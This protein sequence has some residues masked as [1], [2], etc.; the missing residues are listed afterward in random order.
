MFFSCE[1]FSQIDL[2]IIK[3]PDHLLNTI[4]KKL[5]PNGKYANERANFTSEEYSLFNMVFV[6]VIKYLLH[7]GPYYSAFTCLQFCHKRIHSRL[8][9]VSHAQC[10][11]PPVSKINAVCC[12]G[13]FLHSLETLLFYECFYAGQ[14]TNL[15]HRSSYRQQPVINN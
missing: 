2:Q 4:I 6:F 7:S 10:I 9:E 14:Q 3:E 1:T 11:N 12:I 5:L 13:F 15:P 8:K